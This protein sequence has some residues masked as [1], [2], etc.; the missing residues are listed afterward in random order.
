M[1]CI[2][3][4]VTLMVY[5]GGMARE[6]PQIFRQQRPSQS[7]AS[8]SRKQ[9]PAAGRVQRP[10][11][12][13]AQQVSKESAVKATFA[14]VHFKHASPH[15]QHTLQPSVEPTPIAGTA[16]QPQLEEDEGW[17]LLDASGSPES[18]TQPA[19]SQPSLPHRQG[20][21]DDTGQHSEQGHGTQLSPSS[22]RSRALDSNKAG[23]AM[24]S[25]VGH[26]SGDGGTQSASRGT[27]EQSSK[28]QHDQDMDLHAETQGKSLLYPRS[29]SAAAQLTE[30]LEAKAPETSERDELKPLHQQPHNVQQS[31]SH[32][33]EAEQKEQAAS[34]AEPAEDFDRKEVLWRCTIFTIQV[35]HFLRGPSLPV[36]ILP[37]LLHFF[38][39][40]SENPPEIH[41]DRCSAY[42]YR[43]YSAHEV[44]L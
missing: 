2:Y 16:Q 35:P 1:Q 14:T 37:H 4:A 6:W 29:A 41:S 22:G 11:F 24:P 7:A 15:G 23:H 42:T 34:D 30:G 31:D 38:F 20:T 26:K 33:M 13:E 18:T 12:P 32:G 25:H 8:E 10:E 44:L 39:V 36:G 5:I 17:Q 19:S 9:A 43:Q 3:A 28:A 21:V 27:A 40:F